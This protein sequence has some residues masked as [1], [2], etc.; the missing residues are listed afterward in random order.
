MKRD[1]VFLLADG[2]MAAFVQG[3]L[4][5][6]HLEGRLGCRTFAF[7]PLEDVVVDVVSG[8]TDGGLHI[9]GHEILRPYL[10][11]HRHAMVVLD[12]E[13]GGLLPAAEVRRDILT[14]LYRCGWPLGSVDVVVIEPELETWIWQRDN[15][16]VAAAFGY[17]KETPIEVWLSHQGVWPPEALKPDQPKRAAE[18]TLRLTRPGPPIVVYRK[19]AE[20]ISVRHCAD[21]AFHQFRASLGTWFPPEAP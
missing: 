10:R 21:A 8:N 5:R 12:Q 7:D 16:H 6:G 20:K 18:L 17:R 9:R 3:F 13:F 1:C 11:S 19:V 4:C 2:T 14:N 15:P